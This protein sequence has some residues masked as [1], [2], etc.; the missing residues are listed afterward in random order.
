MKKLFMMVLMGGLVFS[1]AACNGEDDME[2]L[3]DAADRLNIY[4][5]D[6]NS[7]TGN[8]VVP[9]EGRNDT[10]IEWEVSPDDVLSLGDTLSGDLAEQE[11]IVTRPVY[12]E[13]DATVTL[14]ATI[15]L[16]DS[17]TTREFEGTVREMSEDFAVYDTIRQLLDSASSGDELQV[18]GIVVGK[19]NHNTFF[20]ADDTAGIS[21]YD[22]PG[23]FI[24]NVSIGD[25]VLV[26]GERGAFNGL[27]QIGFLD[28]VSVLESD[29]SLPDVIDLTGMDIED[30]DAMI[31]YQ[32]QRVAHDE[33]EI[34]TIDE[35]SNATNFEL[36]RSDDATI[37]LRFD[38]RLEDS[39][40][41]ADF[42]Q[43][44]SVG[45]TIDVDGVIMGW[46]NAPQLLVFDEEQITVHD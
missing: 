41:L 13:G 14:I 28:T 37:T 15:L 27:I 44:L 7:I 22:P 8:F 1:L 21:L 31:E 45:D 34:T 35:Q 23:N 17:E 40:D 9:I 42:L 36:T 30:S 5:T 12:G 43:T 24:G 10:T 46:F 38:S 6:I 32:G 39:D 25:H 18:E 26:E 33:M 19:S 3:E 29:Q 4:S 20:I 11:V 2:L 16:G